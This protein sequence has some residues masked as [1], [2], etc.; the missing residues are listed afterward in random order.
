[1]FGTHLTQVRNY[2][3]RLKNARLFGVYLQ[4]FAV[5]VLG[6]SSG[7]VAAVGG[8]NLQLPPRTR[9]HASVVN[10]NGKWKCIHVNAD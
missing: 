5:H 9:F 6:H 10:L 8:F 4:L 2:V 1:M 3:R 7:Q